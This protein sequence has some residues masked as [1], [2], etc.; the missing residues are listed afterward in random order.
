MRTEKYLKLND[1]YNTTIQNLGMQLK[2]YLQEIC[3]LP[4]NI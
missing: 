3:T 2:W 4:W 1:N